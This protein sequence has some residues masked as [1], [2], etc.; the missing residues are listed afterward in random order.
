MMFSLFMII[1]QVGRRRISLLLY[2]KLRLPN[3]LEFRSLCKVIHTFAVEKKRSHLHDLEHP[4]Q[5]LPVDGVQVFQVD[6]S[7]A[8][9]RP[10]Q[11]VLG[12]K[13]RKDWWLTFDGDSPES[14]RSCLGCCTG[15]FSHWCQTLSRACS[16]CA[17]RSCLWSGC[18]CRQNSCELSMK[19]NFRNLT[20]GPSW[21]PK[22]DC[23]QSHRA[24]M[25]DIKNERPR[26]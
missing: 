18:T 21:M 12:A 9:A 3:V 2:W 6:P 16:V 26:G 19:E 25:I 7:P 8:H 14:S 4:G 17:S 10:N 1:W 20:W 15:W 5:F 11:V 13:C 23:P 24:R 22:L